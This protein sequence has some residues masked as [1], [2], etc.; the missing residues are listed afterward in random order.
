MCALVSRRTD[1]RVFGPTTTTNYCPVIYELRFW[2]RERE[3]ER[4][5]WSSW[6]VFL[7][8]FFVRRTAFDEKTPQ[9]SWTTSRCTSRFSPVLQESGNSSSRSLFFLFLAPF[10]RA[11]VVLLARDFFFVSLSSKDA[12]AERGSRRSR[13]CCYYRNGHL[14]SPYRCC[15]DAWGEEDGWLGKQLELES[16]TKEKS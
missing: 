15:R 16:K 5:R 10:E 12:H 11:C 8:F 7:E 9:V 4:K 6:N 3:R 13:P 2:R 1:G 14:A